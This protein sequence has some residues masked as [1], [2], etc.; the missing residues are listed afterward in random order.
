MGGLH[1]PEHAF[2][3]PL[4]ETCKAHPKAPP[5]GPPDKGSHTEL[6]WVTKVLPSDPSEH[7]PH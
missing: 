7:I 3:F 1:K 6:P 2:I 5:L 4:D